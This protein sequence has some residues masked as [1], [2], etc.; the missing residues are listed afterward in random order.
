MEKRRS[1]VVLSGEGVYVPI[2]FR[3]S[4]LSIPAR[5]VFCW[6]WGMHLNSDWVKISNTN[7]GDKLNLSRITIIRAKQELQDL[8]LVDIITTPGAKGISE[9]IVQEERVC[10]YFNLEMTEDDETPTP[11]AKKK[12]ANQSSHRG[13][14]MPQ[15]KTGGMFKY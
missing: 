4:K 14:K 11:K 9:Y 2:E 8:G 7:L 10:E 1:K 3:K 15:A 6:I 5:D 13:K 12:K